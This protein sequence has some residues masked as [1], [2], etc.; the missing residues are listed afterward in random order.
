MCP[1]DF[2]IYTSIFY[3]YY[4]SV[5]GLTSVWRWECEAGYCQKRQITNE[6][7]ETALCL[8]ACRLQCSD[9]AALWPKPRGDFSIGTL[10]KIN[11]NS[12]DVI[13]YHREGSAASLITAAARIFKEGVQV[14][15]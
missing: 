15:K 5:N 11:V 1:G 7:K 6:T 3:H 4:F 8:A 12:I 10:E 14:R 9:S 13:S 2:K